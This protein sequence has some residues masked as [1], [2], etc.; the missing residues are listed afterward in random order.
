MSNRNARLRSRGML[1]SHPGALA[2]IALAGITSLA[3]I[4]L[5]AQEKTQKDTGKD[6]ELSRPPGPLLLAPQGAKISRLLDLEHP[7]APRCL[8]PRADKGWG[9]AHDTDAQPSSAS[10]P[11]FLLRGW[12]RKADRVRLGQRTLVG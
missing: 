5:M 3:A 12:G 11:Q 8:I 1:S 4:S 2:G 6:K 7:A 10:K 9:R